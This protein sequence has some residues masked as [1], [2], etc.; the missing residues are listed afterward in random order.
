MQKMT[1][2][3]RPEY[4]NNNTSV[5]HQSCNS[6][7][8]QKCRKGTQITWI[9][10]IL[11]KDKVKTILWNIFAF[12]SANANFSPILKPSFQNRLSL[13]KPL[14][15]HLVVD[16]QSVNNF[17]NRRHTAVSFPLLPPPLSQ[18]IYFCILVSKHCFKN[19]IKYNKKMV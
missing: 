2:H 3:C 4:W 15:R 14:L 13:Q 12:L 8:F 9:W 19:T 7:S 6:L 16:F 1:S 17:L 11:G 10:F 5:L 18:N